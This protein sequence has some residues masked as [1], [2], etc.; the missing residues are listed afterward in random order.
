MRK[1]RTIL[2]A[3]L[4]TMVCIAMIVVG[5]YALFTDSV[6]LSN[7]L[8]A[9]TL[10][11]KLE[12]T[13]LKWA[14]LDSAGYLETGE[15]A[16]TKD[17]T[18]PTTDNIFGIGEDVL[19]VPGAYYQ[20]TL[21]LTNNGSVAFDY[22]VKIVLK[23]NSNALAEQLIVTVDGDAATAKALSAGE[24]VVSSGSLDKTDSNRSKEFTIKIEFAD[25]EDNNDA[26]E[27]TVNFDLVVVAVQKVG[28]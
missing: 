17:F 3:C 23:S 6:D 27:L 25:V 16:A 28:A 18:E 21:K 24:N 14:K 1:T 11:V 10:K 4:T 12:R 19:V 22:T 9:G 5:T 26:Q 2:A 20:A 7:H 8:Q 13:N 15:D